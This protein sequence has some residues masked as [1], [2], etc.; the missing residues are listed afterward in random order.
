MRVAN[1]WRNETGE[2]VQVYLKKISIASVS[3]LFV[4]AQVR[5]EKFYLALSTQ[6]FFGAISNPIFVSVLSCPAI[7]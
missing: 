6:H 4:C 7:T 2:N 3:Y 1:T 5:L